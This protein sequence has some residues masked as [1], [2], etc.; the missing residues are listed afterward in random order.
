MSDVCYIK[1][2]LLACGIFG[3]IF[4]SLVNLYFSSILAFW[5]SQCQV[6]AYS[7]TF[8]ICNLGLQGLLNRVTC[9]SIEVLVWCLR[10]KNKVEVMGNEQAWCPTRELHLEMQSLSTFLCKKLIIDFY[11]VHHVESTL[12]WF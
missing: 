11:I 8:K 12:M 5:V 10:F 6:D 3:M 4:A 1:D 7:P 9:G 2:L